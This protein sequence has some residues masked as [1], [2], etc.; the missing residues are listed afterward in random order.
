MGQSSSVESPTIH[1]GGGFIAIPSPSRFPL[2]KMGGV[3]W[4]GVEGMWPRHGGGKGILCSHRGNKISS[5]VF[6][7]D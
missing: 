5:S 7:F 2:L 4:N 6:S 1:G 3:G